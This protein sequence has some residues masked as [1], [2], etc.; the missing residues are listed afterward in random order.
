MMAIMIAED[1]VVVGLVLCCLDGWMT[2][3]GIC[4]GRFEGLIT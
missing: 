4:L 2:T 1:A 3:A